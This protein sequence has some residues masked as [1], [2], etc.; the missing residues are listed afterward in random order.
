MWRIILAFRSPPQ[1]IV[2]IWYLMHKLKATYKQTPFT[3]LR[4]FCQYSYS[5]CKRACLRVT[6]KL[7]CVSYTLFITHIPG[8][9]Q[10]AVG[11]LTDKSR[12]ISKPCEMC[13]KLTDRSAIRQAP[14]QYIGNYIGMLPLFILMLLLIVKH[15]LPWILVLWCQGKTRTLT[16]CAYSIAHPH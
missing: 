11:R 13:L 5:R 9:S 7:A 10:Q 2:T 4:G 12:E 3:F 6:G 8:F 16:F 14:R 15:P 1:V